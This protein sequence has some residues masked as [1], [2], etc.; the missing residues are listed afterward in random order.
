V[1][2]RR[3][4]T[5]EFPSAEAVVE[6]ALTRFLGTTARRDP[7]LPEAHDTR[8]V[9]AMTVDGIENVGTLN[10]DD[11]AVYKNV[12]VIHPHRSEVWRLFLS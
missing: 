1:I 5:A 3:V 9:A 11:F 10:A 12:R 2:E 7:A 4:R 6:S 8:V